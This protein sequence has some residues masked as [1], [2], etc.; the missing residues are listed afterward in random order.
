MTIQ[1]Y[2]QRVMRLIAEVN[3]SAK[4][5]ANILKHIELNDIDASAI[6]SAAAQFQQAAKDLHQLDGLVQALIM[7]R[8][9]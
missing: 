6:R 5:G 9:K 4:S 2:D 1:H 8:L 3:E 7:M